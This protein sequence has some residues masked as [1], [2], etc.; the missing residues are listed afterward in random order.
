MDSTESRHLFI[1]FLTIH[2]F[3]F[4]SNRN[5]EEVEKLLSS[6]DEPGSPGE[7]LCHPLCS[8]EKCEKLHTR[9]GLFTKLRLV[10][11][12]ARSIDA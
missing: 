7:K 10:F 6:A 4:A 12:K 8:C 1:Y 9:Y 2:Y 11:N 3:Q 5:E